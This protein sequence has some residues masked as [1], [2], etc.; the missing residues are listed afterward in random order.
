VRLAKSPLVA[1]SVASKA[2]NIVGTPET[3]RGSEGTLQMCQPQN[4][5]AGLNSAAIKC[6]KKAEL[7]RPDFKLLK[8]R[9]PMADSG[10]QQVSGGAQGHTEN[11]NLPWVAC[12]MASQSTYAHSG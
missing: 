8:S 2:G 9:P 11:Q 6:Q 1:C 3:V 7:T 12:S 5:Q 10:S 4:R